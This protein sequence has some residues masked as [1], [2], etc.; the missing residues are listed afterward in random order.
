[1]E[2]ILDDYMGIIK[3]TLIYL[4]LFF[5]TFEIAAAQDITLNGKVV[6]ANDNT[7]LPYVNINIPAIGV[8]TVSNDEGEFALKFA[9]NYTAHDSIVFSFIGYKTKSINIRDAL[10]TKELTVILTP[11]IEQL[12][13][14]AIKPLSVKQLL[15]SIVQHNQSAFISP[16]KLNGY[17]REF[18]FTNAKCT[19]YADAL[20]KY[21]HNRAP[22][23][24]GQLKI[25]ASRCEKATAKKIDSNNYESFYVDSKV[26]ADLMFRYATLSELIAHYFPD[27]RLTNY[28]YTIQVNNTNN[29]LLVVIYPKQYDAVFFIYKIQFRLSDDFTLKYYRLEVPDG[30]LKSIKEASLLGI[31]GKFTGLTVEARYDADKFGVY[32]EYFKYTSSSYIYGKCLGVSINQTIDRKSEFVITGID[33]VDRLPFPRN[34]IYKKGNICNNG[35]AINTEMLKSYNFIKPTQKD[36]LAISAITAI[37]PE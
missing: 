27:N 30:E 18:V 6:A 8:S 24:G 33:T 5:T 1:M 29:D 23:V 7:G 19:E 35:A 11:S 25:I 22:K 15:D 34:E 21:Y 12:K 9:T 32:P 36:S 28:T 13:E 16:M 14:V 26:N 3:I 37:Q 31:H 20:I 2:Y 10:K 17:Y 4:F